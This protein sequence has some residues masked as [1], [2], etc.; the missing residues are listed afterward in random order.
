MFHVA[1]F[2][3][4]YQN[5]NEN[6]DLIM[7]LIRF[8]NLKVCGVSQY[9]NCTLSKNNYIQRDSDTFMSKKENGYIYLYIY[10]YIFFFWG[11]DTFILDLQNLMHLI[12]K[13]TFAL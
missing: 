2:V 8:L 1:T 11:G 6:W 4:F 9:K 10:I 7:K 3:T 13:V 12:F 5:L